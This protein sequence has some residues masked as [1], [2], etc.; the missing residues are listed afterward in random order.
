VG[1]ESN[2]L[3]LVKNN[4]LISLPV[5]GDW[6]IGLTPNKAFRVSYP[7]VSCDCALLRESRLWDGDPSRRDSRILSFHLTM[8][9]TIR[10]SITVVSLSISCSC[11]FAC[12]VSTKDNQSE[13][14]A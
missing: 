11:W 8:L 4:V 1:T 6:V 9:G 14:P 13:R 7:Q 2:S 5:G 12:L 10:C 3:G